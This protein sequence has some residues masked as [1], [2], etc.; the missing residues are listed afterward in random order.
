MA[1]FVELMKSSEERTRSR[2]SRVAAPPAPASTAILSLACSTVARISDFFSSRLDL[3]FARRSRHN[4]S[5]SR[6]SKII[7]E[8][9]RFLNVYK[10]EGDENPECDCS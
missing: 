4:K 9:T 10:P 7:D 2:L 5:K 8:F 3:G 6:V 1:S